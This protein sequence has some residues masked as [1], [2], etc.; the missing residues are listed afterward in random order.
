VIVYRIV[1]S[2]FA[3]EAYSGKGAEDFPGRWNN[4]GIPVVYTSGSLALCA[5][6]LFVH[7]NDIGRQGRYV[8]IAATIPKSVAIS[9]IPA[10]R[11]PEDWKT[12]PPSAEARNL[13]SQ[14]AI[15]KKS[16]VLKVPSVVVP[17][18]FNYVL[19]PRHPEFS[20]IRINGPVP[21]LYDAR[22]W[23]R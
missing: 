8:S 12:D 1:D 4:K 23:K 22:M 18:E 5:M 6:E 13:G 14:W 15:S 3:A 17:G 2:E 7:L 19:N 9:S 16:A 10:S 21:F 20:K 11:L